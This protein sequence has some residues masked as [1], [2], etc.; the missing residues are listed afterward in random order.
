MTNGTFI[1]RNGK[2]TGARPGRALRLRD[3]VMPKN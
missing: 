1:W 3:Q 2:P